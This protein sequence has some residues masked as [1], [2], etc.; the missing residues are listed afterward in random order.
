MNTIRNS[1]QAHAEEFATYRRTLHQN[2]QTAFEE[3]FASDFVAEKLSE[4]GIAFERGF[5][6]T[7]IVATI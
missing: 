7:G 6:K 3:N 1:I 4:W 5:G 2:P